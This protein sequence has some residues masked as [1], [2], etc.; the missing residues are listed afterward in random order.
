MKL[1]GFGEEADAVHLGH[2]LVGQKKGHRIVASLEFAQGGNGG[3]AGVRAHDPVAVRITAA[4]IALDGAQDLRVVVDREQNW[5]G[6]TPQ[7]S[8]KRISLRRRKSFCCERLQLG[9]PS[10]YNSLRVHV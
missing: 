5:F 9:R 1:H 10:R 8:G 6:H 2:A 4:Q 3:A 7:M